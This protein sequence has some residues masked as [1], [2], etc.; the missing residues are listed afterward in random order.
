[1]STWAAIGT[2][3]AVWIGSTAI[4]LAVLVWMG[5]RYDR[6]ALA[7]A[8]ERHPACGHD[9]VIRADC[10]AWLGPASDGW[11]DLEFNRITHVTECATCQHEMEGRAA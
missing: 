7:E 6:A 2:V 5:R 4:L 3:V 8:I 11:W 10:G 9:E 1:M